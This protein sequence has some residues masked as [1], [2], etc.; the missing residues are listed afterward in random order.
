MWIMLLQP[1]CWWRGTFFYSVSLA[2]C[3]TL[4]LKTAA[5]SFSERLL[6]NWFWGCFGCC[7]VTQWVNSLES[8][9]VQSPVYV[10]GKAFRF[11]K[12][13]LHYKYLKVWTFISD[14]VTE[15]SRWL[16]ISSQYVQ[17]VKILSTRLAPH[18][19]IFHRY[20]EWR[21]LNCRRCLPRCHA[22]C[23]EESSHWERPTDYCSSQVVTTVLCWNVYLQL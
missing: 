17:I 6:R 8:G 4:E 3:Q 18:Y 1:E 15:L 5:K 14:H 16:D 11:S 2:L 19:I 7:G 23:Q 13:S 21:W 10:F 22:V 12:N 20:V 9:H